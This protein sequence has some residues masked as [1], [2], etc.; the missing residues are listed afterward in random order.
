MI[1]T[2]ANLLFLI[3]INE[4]IILLGL[5]EEKGAYRMPNSI[6]EGRMLKDSTFRVSHYMGEEYVIMIEPDHG[7]TGLIYLYVADIVGWRLVPDWGVPQSLYRCLNNEVAT[8]K[9]VNR[10]F[11]EM[12][13][14]G[15]FGFASDLIGLDD[16]SPGIR[17]AFAGIGYDKS[18]HPEANDLVSAS[19]YVAYVWSLGFGSSKV[20]DA[21]LL[22]SGVHH[23]VECGAMGP[24]AFQYLPEII[25][26]YERCG[27]QAIVKLVCSMALVSSWMSQGCGKDRR[28]TTESLSKM[29]E[30]VGLGESEE[31]ALRELYS[32]ERS[33]ERDWWFKC[34]IWGVVKILENTLDLKPL[35]AMLYNC[36]YSKALQPPFFRACL[37]ISLGSYVTTPKKLKMMFPPLGGSDFSFIPHVLWVNKMEYI[38]E[39]RRN[40]SMDRGTPELDDIKNSIEFSDIRGEFGTIASHSLCPEFDDQLT[41]IEIEKF[42]GVISGLLGRSHLAKFAEAPGP[43][44]IGQAQRVLQ[45][46]VGRTIMEVPVEHYNDGLESGALLEAVPIAKGIQGGDAVLGTD[47]RKCGTGDGLC[48]ACLDYICCR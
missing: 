4:N 38:L 12:E 43:V 10:S 47:C 45:S 37:S 36:G 24:N 15:Q 8:L 13:D 26:M 32:T 1:S 31:L 30:T 17:S 34:D 44:E 48:K 28:G 22:L 25:R 19:E 7:K 21:H 20:P 23:K 16:W 29:R 5:V 9:S 14:F 2:K 42:A 6:D 40:D 27:V 39:A 35:L 46:M 3:K 11:N 33:Y 41:Q 18:E